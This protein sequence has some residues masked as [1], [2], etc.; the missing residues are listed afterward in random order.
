V[1]K[2]DTLHST[3]KRE[4]SQGATVADDGNDGKEEEE[5]AILRER[6]TRN[7]PVSKKGA[8]LGRK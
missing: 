5:D 7:M 1:T 3:A 2:T 8:I 6:C 4:I